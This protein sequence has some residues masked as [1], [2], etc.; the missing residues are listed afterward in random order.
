MGVNLK[1]L[2]NMRLASARSFAEGREGAER[3]GLPWDGARSGAN[4]SGAAL[5]GGGDSKVFFL[6]LLNHV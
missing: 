4:P 5:W 3:F 6:A 1:E 2:E